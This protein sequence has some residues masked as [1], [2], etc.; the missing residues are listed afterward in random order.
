MFT[1]K[2]CTRLKSTFDIRD[3]LAS[4]GCLCGQGLARDCDKPCYSGRYVV[5]IFQ[6]KRNGE[7]F[8]NGDR[9]V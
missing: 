4:G 2:Y 9:E 6:V 7:Q 8:K 3:L 1:V 5:V